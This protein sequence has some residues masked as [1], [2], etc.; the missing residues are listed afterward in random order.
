MTFDSKPS[1]DKAYDDAVSTLISRLASDL[2]ARPSA[3]PSV[4]V[5]FGTHNMQSCDLVKDTL[6]K[7][8]LGQVVEGGKVRLMEGVAGRVCTGQ[9]YG[10]R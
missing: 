6:I 4:G 10:E 2:K 3:T 8:G 9:L 5:Y 7:E 1:T